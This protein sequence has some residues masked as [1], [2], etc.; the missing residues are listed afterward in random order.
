[1][2][3]RNENRPGYRKT[4]AGWIPGVWD[5]IRFDCVFQRIRDEVIVKPEQEYFEIGIRSHGKG[6]FHKPAVQGS[7]LGNKS[8]FWVHQNALVFNIVFAWEQAVSVTSTT[9]SGFIASHRFPMY[10][11]KSKKV[12]NE[13]IYY[14]F[15]SDN[16]KH[17]LS[18]ASPGGAG[19]NRTLGQKR[20]ASTL[21]PL[22]PLPEQIMIAEILS[23]WDEAIEQTRKLIEAKK[24]RKKALMQQLL[25]GKKRLPGFSKS[26][27]RLSFRFFSIPADW[28][29]PR[30]SE[31]AEEHSV[32]N[33][34]D[35]QLKVYTC[36]KH[37]GFV[38]SLKYF[39]KRVFSEDTSNYKLVYHNWFGFPS[40]HVEEG[41]IGLLY[42]DE[43]GIVSPIY[44]VFS[45]NE[46][47]DPGYM[48]SVLKTEIYRHIFAISTNASVNRRGSLRWREF[49]QIRI[50]LP[51]IHEQ[52]AIAR[53]LF[54][55]DK[56]IKALD[57]K[58]SAL[59]KQKRGL[60]QK[61]LTG[62]IRTL[63]RSEKVRSMQ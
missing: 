33:R 7:A 25:T 35:L 40:N 62:T 6:I 14:F 51:S 50:P 63:K 23:T 39:G 58:L 52:H 41:S 42:Q 43:Q 16:G 59:M 8:V 45:F 38:E 49:S 22:P 55:S 47:V 17:L 9:E 56:E 57:E 31:V 34:D 29:C 15:L 26:E 53:V 24:R 46:K 19:R 36:S 3:D 11:P 28:N 48:F 27:P 32:R 60:M 10:V 21:I 1:M 44:V 12:S 20:I 61:L 13:Y 18:L 54:A 5:Y 30:V 2:K 37:H 4:K